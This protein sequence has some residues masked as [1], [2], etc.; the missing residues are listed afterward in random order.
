MVHGSWGTNSAGE[1]RP[2]HK[3]AGLSDIVTL[4]TKADGRGLDICAG[5]QSVI[6]EREKAFYLS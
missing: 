2:T 4:L 6:G 5:C 1:T 3:L